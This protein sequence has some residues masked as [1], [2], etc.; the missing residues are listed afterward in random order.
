MALDFPFDDALD[1]LRAAVATAYAIPSGHAIPEAGNQPVAVN[2]DAL[3]MA[4]L[5]TDGAAVISRY[6]DAGLV[7]L[8][9]VF[10]VYCWL[11]KATTQNTDDVAGLRADLVALAQALY[12]DPTLGNT[13]TDMEVTAI[14][15]TGQGRPWPF[16]NVSG[17]GV[18]CG[19]VAVRLELV[20]A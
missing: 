5:E 14:N 10:T 1:S 18:I 9:E 19:Y 20:D 16:D 17:I 6:E 12:A 2:A 3:P 4:A 13:V 8:K 11:L 7:P 15:W